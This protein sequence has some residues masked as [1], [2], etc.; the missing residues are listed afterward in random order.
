MSLWENRWHVWERHVPRPEDITRNPDGTSSFSLGSGIVT[1]YIVRAHS[2]PGKH[3]PYEVEF[4]PEEKDEARAL[5]DEFNRYERQ[6]PLPEEFA[7]R[8]ANLAKVPGNIFGVIYGDFGWN[9]PP[10]APE[11][12]AVVA[13]SDSYQEHFIDLTDSLD[14]ARGEVA[15]EGEGTEIWDLD[16]GKKLRVDIAVTVRT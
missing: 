8:R 14:E 15:S 11:R 16:T 3:E 9:D 10:V 2:Y 1:G 13:Y 4:A 6:G 7:E 5:A 12:Y